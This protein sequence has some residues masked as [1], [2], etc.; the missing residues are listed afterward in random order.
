[1]DSDYPVLNPGDEEVRIAGVEAWPRQGAIRAGL[2][3]EIVG[4]PGQYDDRE[5]R[6][7]HLSQDRIGG[8]DALFAGRIDVIAGLDEQ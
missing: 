1:M 7:A 8:G 5:V 4:C 2:Q 6:I 3:D